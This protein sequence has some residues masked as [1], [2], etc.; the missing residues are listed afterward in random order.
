MEMERDWLCVIVHS[1]AKSPRRYTFPHFSDTSLLVLRARKAKGEEERKEVLCVFRA[2][3]QY[4]RVL[5]GDL[6]LSGRERVKET[7]IN[8]VSRNVLRCVCVSWCS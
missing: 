6:K 4:C 8:S 1:E 3:C 5:E 2:L 7:S